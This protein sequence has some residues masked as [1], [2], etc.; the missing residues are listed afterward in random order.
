MRIS[1]WSSDLC[2]SDLRA[3]PGGAEE[4]GVPTSYYSAVQ[5]VCRPTVVDD[6]RGKAE[7]LAT[8]LADFQPEGRIAD[9]AV[10][11]SPYGDRT[12]IEQGTSVCV[13]VYP[14]VG[15]IHRKKTE[16]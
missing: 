5:F 11:A 2:S 4:D 10:D 8:Q 9:V 13:S 3:K 6:P 7:L 12:T 14:V 1:D 15:C 16:D